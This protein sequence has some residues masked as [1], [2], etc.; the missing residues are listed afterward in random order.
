[1]K[2]NLYRTGK[3]LYICFIFCRS[4]L[5]EVIGHG[6]GKSFIVQLLDMGIPVS[7]SM[8]DEAHGIVITTPRVN[9]K[10]RRVFS[11]SSDVASPMKMKMPSL[12][13]EESILED[14]FY[15]YSLNVSVYIM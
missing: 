13:E 7:P 3:A 9:T 8:I 2:K 11:D 4:L 10:V 1:M 6:K 15:G 12:T 5:A 14:T